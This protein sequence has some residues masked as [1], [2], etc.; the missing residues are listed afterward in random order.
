MKNIKKGKKLSRLLRHRANNDN[1]PMN[2]A[3]W[4]SISDVLAL[5]NLTLEELKQIVNTDKKARYEIQDNMIRAAQGHSRNNVPVT[6]TALEAS[7]RLY[8]CT[9]PVYHGTKLQ[10]LKSI[11]KRGILPVNRTHVHLSK[12]LNSITGKRTNVDVMLKICPQKIRQGGNNI[13]ETSNQVI[14]ARNIPTHA[15]LGCIPITQTAQ[16]QTAAITS[17]FTILA[18]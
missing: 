13:Y 1:L 11:R 16:M 3:G 18:H 4:S 15:I 17:Y 9:K 7:W 14:L 10:H 8:E 12:S 6:I 5:T 2:P